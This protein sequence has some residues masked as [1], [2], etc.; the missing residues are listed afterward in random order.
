MKILIR[1][2]QDTLDEIKLKI[3]LEIVSRF[4]VFTIKKKSIENLLRWKSNG[5]WSVSYE[6]WL[7]IL[8]DRDEQKLIGCMTGLDQ[9]SNQM[10]Q[11]MPYVGLLDQ[12]VVR[13]IHE[14]I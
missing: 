11:S 12:S 1:N 8:N 4:D 13:K 7:T 10:R 6:L 9:R 14:E 5:T 2:K 3:S